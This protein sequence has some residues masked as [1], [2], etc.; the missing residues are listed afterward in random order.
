MGV[1]DIAVI[2]AAILHDTVEDTETSLEE[3]E[4]VFGKEVRDLVDDVTD[5]KNKEKAE[6][7]RLQIVHAAHVCDKAKLVKL[8]DK[9]YNLRDLERASPKG[10]TEERKQ[11]YFLW[12]A[13]VRAGSDILASEIMFSGGA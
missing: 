3:L 2:Q 6:R 7:K 13:K 12:G 8:A 11:E 5:D 1:D 4:Q 9:L 10:W